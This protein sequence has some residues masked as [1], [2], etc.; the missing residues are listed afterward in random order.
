[1]TYSYY[2][3]CTLKTKGKELDIY[4][5]EC[6]RALGVTMEEI[7]DWQCCGAVYP[8]A[9]DEIATRLSSA[10]ALINAK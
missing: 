3:G 1:M 10:R 7:E 4:A 6:A 8:Q 2:P 5:R 9:N